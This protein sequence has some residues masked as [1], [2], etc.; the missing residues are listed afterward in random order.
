MANKKWFGLIALSVAAIVVLGVGLGVGLGLGAHSGGMEPID[1]AKERVRQFEG[2]A[3]A[4]LQQMSVPDTDLIQLTDGKTVYGYN[5][6]SDRI[7]LVIY[8]DNREGNQPV[9]ITQEQAEAIATKFAQEH[10]Q[11]LSIFTL[12]SSELTG[13]ADPAYNF[14]WVQIIDGALTPNRVVVSVNPGTGKIMAYIYRYQPLKSAG[15]PTL[16]KEDAKA[17]VANRIVERAGLA[18]VTNVTLGGVSFLQE[19]ELHIVVKDGNEILVWQVSAEAVGNP[20]IIIG[21][22]FDVDAH[23]GDIVQ[24]NPFL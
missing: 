14:E 21:G 6:Q 22:E 20:P 2:I 7:E 3:I 17:I 8:N 23:T 16:T 12:H 11:N 1:K 13:P 9:L 10:C 15:S 19:P 18:K 4:D 5:P 24:E